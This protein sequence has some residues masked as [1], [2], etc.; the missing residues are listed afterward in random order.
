M[1]RT[2]CT[3]LLHIKRRDQSGLVHVSTP[4]FQATVRASFAPSTNVAFCTLS[5]LLP[6][7]LCNEAIDSKV[8]Y[9]F[10]A[11]FETRRIV[12]R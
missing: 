10:F 8:E 3:A 1:A 2:L 4:T 11:C 6:N 5:A 12:A 9:Q 7:Y